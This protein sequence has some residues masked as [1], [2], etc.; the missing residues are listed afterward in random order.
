MWATIPNDG[1]KRLHAFTE[2]GREESMVVKI[3]YF[4]QGSLSVSKV[5][6]AGNRLVFDN[7]SNS[8]DSTMRGARSWLKDNQEHSF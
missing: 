7:A 4:N 2:D 6:K 8:V 5:V 1:E 3:C